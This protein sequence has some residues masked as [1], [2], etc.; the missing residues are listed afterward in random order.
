MRQI[1]L[2]ALL[3][4]P[5]AAQAAPLDGHWSVDATTQVGDCQRSFEGEF[6]V[7]QGAILEAEGGAPAGYIEA[8][9]SAWARFTRNGQVARG[10]GKFSGASA[11]GTWSSNT[12]YCGG[13][14][15]AHKLR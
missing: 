2:A 7:A 1:L 9:G 4:F 13:H 3:V 15:R 14:W 11:S 5:V 10:Q 6:V 12:S 8:N